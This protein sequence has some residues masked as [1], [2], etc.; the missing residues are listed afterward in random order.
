MK[1]G[2]SGSP[3]ISVRGVTN[4]TEDELDEIIIT[5]EFADIICEMENVCFGESCGPDAK[6]LMLQISKKY[7]VLKEKYTWLPWPNDEE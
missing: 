2:Q 1:N 7:P 3:Q 5:Y 4:M 6:E